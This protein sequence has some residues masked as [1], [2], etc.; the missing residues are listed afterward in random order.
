MS[1]IA[2]KNRLK[3]ALRE[4]LARIIVPIVMTARSTLRPVHIKDL[5][6]VIKD[7]YVIGLFHISYKNIN[8]NL[9][10]NA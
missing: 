1:Y 10:N 8:F 9:V 3:N 7:K 2:L 5:M 4:S 6:P